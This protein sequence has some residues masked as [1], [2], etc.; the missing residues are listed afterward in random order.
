MLEIHKK[1]FRMKYKQLPFDE[2]PQADLQFL[3]REVQLENVKAM[4]EIVDPT[5]KE[6]EE[7]KVW[8]SVI[9]AFRSLSSNGHRKIGEVGYAHDLDV[10]ITYES[11]KA[12]Y[13]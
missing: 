11:I 12:S 2:F 7:N 10:Y 4:Y 8:F 5:I 9:S 13:S 3:R 6:N 1:S